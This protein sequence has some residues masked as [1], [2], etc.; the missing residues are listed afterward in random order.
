[1]GLKAHPYSSIRTRTS[2]DTVQVFYGKAVTRARPSEGFWLTG[3]AG[4]HTM[5]AAGG[6]NYIT[7]S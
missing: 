4:A 1:M 6:K 3:E 5:G 7:P 2:L